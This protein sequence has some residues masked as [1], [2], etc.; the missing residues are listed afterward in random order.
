MI[1]LQIFQSV[2]NPLRSSR[3]Y[4]LFKEKD[5]SLTILLSFMSSIVEQEWTKIHT[6]R[7]T[8]KEKVYSEYLNHLIRM[9]KALYKGFQESLGSDKVVLNEIDVGEGELNLSKEGIKL[10]NGE[11]ISAEEYVERV[12]KNR[13]Y[14]TEFGYIEVSSD[15]RFQKL[16]ILITQIRFYEGSRQK[17]LTG[18]YLPKHTGVI[19]K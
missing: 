3:N 15:D 4:P 10:K 13:H 8:V 7:E 14:V 18:K 17:T 2:F 12:V 19:K 5:K 6:E 11:V 9:T 16:Q 1:F